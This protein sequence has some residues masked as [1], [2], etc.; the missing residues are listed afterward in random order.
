[1][2]ANRMF[3]LPLNQINGSRLSYQWNEAAKNQINIVSLADSR[4]VE[5]DYRGKVLPAA[6]RAS[7]LL[8]TVR[9]NDTVMLWANN[10]EYS[11]KVLGMEFYL[12]K[13]PKILVQWTSGKVTLESI[14]TVNRV[15]DK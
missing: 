4:P 8:A 11:A 13:A 15:S 9:I 7:T 5:V 6:G 12:D 10:R 14:Q 3:V 1:V 2:R